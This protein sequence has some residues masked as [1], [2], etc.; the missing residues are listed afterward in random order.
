MSANRIVWDGLAE[1]RAELRKLP[2]DLTGE[3]VHPIEA[4]ANSAA[5]TV[6]SVYGQH[7][8]SGHLRDSVVVESR[9]SSHFGVTL[10]VLSKDPIAWIFDNGSQARHWV[11]GK[12]TGTMWGRTPPTHTFV[13]TMIRERKRMYEQLKD[14]LRRHGLWVSG[15]A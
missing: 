15:D 6:K 5:A 1:L 13:S 12:S 10:V 9:A 11:S 14:L 7:A 8:V 4:A 3:A 2:S